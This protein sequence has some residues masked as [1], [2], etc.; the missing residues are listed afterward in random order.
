MS[1]I[2]DPELSSIL[3]LPSS[4][5]TSFT[6]QPMALMLPKNSARV[7]LDPSTKASLKMEELLR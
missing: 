6:R 4:P 5:T 3:T 7:A 1:S 2:S